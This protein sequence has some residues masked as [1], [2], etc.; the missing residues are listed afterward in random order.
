MEPG[1]LLIPACPP[2]E[3][4]QDRRGK[5]TK[6]VVRHQGLRAKFKPLGLRSTPFHAAF[7]FDFEF[8]CD[9]KRTGSAQGLSVNNLL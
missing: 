4:R 5:S 1:C 9:E 6:F 2:A 8:A 3:S 7:D